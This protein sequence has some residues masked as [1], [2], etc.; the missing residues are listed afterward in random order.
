M[1]EPKALSLLNSGRGIDSPIVGSFSQLQAAPDYSVPSIYT[2][3]DSSYCQPTP[4][5]DGAGIRHE[6]VW[7]DKGT[8]EFWFRPNV[9]S[10]NGTVMTFPPTWGAPIRYCASID[11]VVQN[12]IPND[13][14]WCPI[15]TFEFGNGTGISWSYWDALKI[16]QVM[17]ITSIVMLANIW[18]HFAFTWDRT[19]AYPTRVMYFDGNGVGITGQSID[20]YNNKAVALSIGGIAYSAYGGFSDMCSDA[21][22]AGYRQHNFVKTDFS[23][24]FNLRAGMNDLIIT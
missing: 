24:R 18:Y 12:G 8:I 11:W 20:S 7:G 2:G 1:P 16:Y 22:F 17:T 13:V 19:A 5:A 10:I 23:D 4:E 9:W 6:G 14:M 21:N 15:Y 3:Y